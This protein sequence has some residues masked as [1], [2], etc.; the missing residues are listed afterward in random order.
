[1]YIPNFGMY[2]SWFGTYVSSF[3]IYVPNFG[4]KPSPQRKNIFTTVLQQFKHYVS[5]FI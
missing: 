4:T 5:T 2:V 3:G 1:M